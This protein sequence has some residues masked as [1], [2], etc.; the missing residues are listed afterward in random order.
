MV[1]KILEITS[2]MKNVSK[3]KV[4]YEEILS[5]FEKRESF[6]SVMTASSLL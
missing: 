3:Q 5:N 2:H 1:S 6:V 4:S